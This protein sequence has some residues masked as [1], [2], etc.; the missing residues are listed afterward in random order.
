MGFATNAAYVHI[1]KNETAETRLHLGELEAFA[2]GVTPNGSGGATFGGMATSTNDIGDGTLSAFGVGNI[3]PA[4]GTTNSI[5]HGSANQNPDNLLQK[6]GAVWSTN[7][8]QATASQ[9][10]LSL[11]GTHDVT[12]IRMWPRADNCC[13]DRWRNLEIQLLDAGRN[14]IPGTK[15][16]AT[17][18]G[19]N[20]PLEFL[21]PDASSINRFGLSPQTIASDDPVTLSWN[22]DPAVTAV[23]IDQSIGNVMPQTAAGIGSILLDPGPTATTTYTLSVTS[24]G[25][26]STAEVTVTVDNDPIIHSFGSN[27]T[28]VS[29]GIDVTL[30]WDVSNFDELRL[31]GSLVEGGGTS[32][33][34]TPLV[35][36]TYTLD[37]SNAQGSA[38]A[39]LT[40]TV[41]NV[42]GL[43]GASGRF[44]EVVKNDTANTR[45]H[46]SEIEVFQFG[47][48]PNEA[49]GDG[50][51]SNDLIQN[52]SPSTETPPTTTSLDHGD[53]NFVFNGEIESG[54]SVWSTAGD[55]GVEPRYMLDL[56]GSN[57]INTVRIFGRGD[58]CCFDR[59]Q[60]FTVNIYA[61]DGTG[62]PG[63][64]VNSEHFSG[65]APAG[66]AGNIE[67]SLA[68]PDP[69]I[70][71]FS[72]DKSFIP[73]GEAITLAWEV[74]SESSGVSISNI[75]DVTA[76]TDAD[77]VGSILV[78][79]GPDSNTTYTLTAVRPNG[80]STAQISVEVTDQPLIFSFTAAAGIVSP[81]TIVN[82][83]WEVGNVSA[84][85]LN[86][87]D[88]TGLNGTSVMPLST[89]SYTLTAT[90]ANGSISDEVRIRVAL[91][92]EPFISEFMTDNE[93]GLTDEDGEFSDWI[94]VCNPTGD[95]ATLDGYFLT[96]D[97]LT[98]TKWRLPD[99][100]IPPGGYLVIFA[101]GKN[102]AVPGSELHANFSLGRNGEYLALV[103]PDGVTIVTEFSPTYPNQRSDVSF[104]FDSVDLIEGF[105]LNP[106]PGVEN[107]GGF[108]DF[109]ADTSFALDRGFYDAPISVV[110]SS[111]TPG[112]EIR[113][114]VNG[115]KPTP[116]TGLV[117]TAA[118][119]IARTTVLRAAAFKTGHVPTNIDTH[120]YIFPTD[121]IAHPN[122]RTSVT[123]NPTYAS[124]MVDAL[125]AVPTI[126]LVFQGD[127][128]RNEKVASVELINF[129]A[130]DTQL[131]AGMERF[132]N[133]ATN[134]A[135]RG[136]R[137]SF[138]DIYGPGKLTFPVFDGHDYPTP[139][140]AKIDAIDLRSGNHDMSSRGAY[141][142]NRF[143]DDTMLDMGQIAPHGRFVHIYLN[144][145]YWGQYH[146]RE[147]WN[148]AMMSEY[149][150]GGK[151]DYEAINA[152]N[153][154]NEFLTGTPFDGTGQYWN[155]TQSLINGGTPFSTA[156]NHID[157]AN[158]FN[159]ML[160]W[161]SGN[162][163][164]EFRS[165]GSVPLG[166]PFK[167]FM[168]DADGFLRSS[169]RNLNHNG[170][171]NVM[172]RLA[173]EANPDYKTLL[174]DEIHRHYFNDGAFT[175]ARNIAR[176]QARVDEIKVSFLGESA[177]WGEQTPASWQGFQDNL[178]NNYFP[179]LT[180]TMISRFTSGGYYPSVVAPSFNQ[181]GGS[182]APGFVLAM[183]APA[184]T[185]YYTLDGSDPRESADPV[186]VAPPITILAEAAAKTVYVPTGASD[187]FTDGGG[188]SWND[189]AFDD[190]GWTSGNGGV[191]YEQG[192]GYQ[193]FFDINVETDM[194]DKET[195]CLIR[196]PFTI[197]AGALTDKTG[198]EIRVRYDDAYVA[199]L[200]GTEIARRNFTGIP[201]GVSTGTNHADGAAV[202]LESVDISAH[203]ALL[204]EG[205][206]NLLAIHGINTST[207]SS[208][209]LISAELRVSEVPAGGGVGGII[210]PTAIEYT[211]TLPIASTT[212][213][214][215]RVFDG[216]SWS[217]LTE[218]TFTPGFS[219]LAVSEIMYNPFPSSAEEIAA[220]HGDSGN[221]EF[222]ELLNSGSSPLDLSGV[223][224][225]EGLAFDFT[226]SAVTSLAPGERVLIV[227]DLVAFEF[228]YGSGLPVAGQ[229]MGRLNNG[230]ENV[231]LIDALDQTIRNFAYGNV[232]PWPAAPDGQGP[233]LLLIDP[234]SNPDHSDPENWIAGSFGGMPGTGELG[235]Q[236]F[237]DWAIAN[238]VVEPSGDPDGDGIVNFLEFFSGTNPNDSSSASSPRIGIDSDG[239]ATLGVRQ[240]LSAG[241]VD[242]QFETSR[243]LHVW[244]TEVTAEV[245]EVTHNGD[246]TV[247]ATYRTLADVTSIERVFIRLRISEQ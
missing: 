70:R 130:G 90:N 160:L 200:N 110:I 8:G 151:E 187:G 12:T 191:G 7:P 25:E 126:S 19:G 199:Y 239:R 21:F 204:N 43:L 9:Y 36:T 11:G 212:T 124:Q 224:F 74:N 116:T 102:R 141:M 147:R 134:F 53:P 136:M 49:D 169:G 228:R 139:P 82:L 245:V 242:V 51:S 100:T 176:L 3:Y 114:T 223:R 221:F 149:F 167:F 138:R 63:E 81:G 186:V 206:E 10:T 243:D 217:A 157:M 22:V 190:N 184:G 218:A 115:S 40:I 165:A 66:N 219:A 62:S 93:S 24:G 185:I 39:D 14:P 166:V 181:H 230:G 58:A 38:S 210:S 71:S 56:G 132:G 235:Q 52:G 172:S 46:I 113:Y 23:T 60:N 119:P 244:V 142:S 109:V 209:F 27:H 152:N 37:A 189:L 91:P 180:N 17:A 214:Q 183:T 76:M 35:T 89:T 202:V 59:L 31:N 103:R 125:K 2:R 178:L 246:G 86:G 146:M 72:V 65:T 41:I 140:A 194:A 122:M 162:S 195:T 128:E 98:Q 129:E 179:G 182:V 55:L 144:G 188:N 88:V 171:L 48:N 104:G 164:S 208:D 231:H 16:L 153:A 216:S 20:I 68:I 107:T 137:I 192:S 226:G 5:Q 225:T 4:L 196:I 108:T 42:P 30:M 135:K 80:T 94:E 28:S 57:T 193:N 170:P 18:P 215:A 6:A 177:R 156:R 174:A 97:P 33:V 237:G 78:N 117:Y 163:E 234:D 120:T 34:V 197:A 205:G 232:E 101:S 75:G 64:L 15:V 92:G 150:G 127:V 96:D 133:Y 99:V 220:G 83:T 227:N 201:N 207:G 44:I 79:P 213:A 175:P 29:P 173:S 222:L 111:A 73:Q 47:V 236:S 1:L 158:V 32:I 123:Q 95:P 198:A 87:I 26:V 241:G 247:T 45:L 148:A 154:G 168:K 13:S 85:D 61:D 112:A 145:L 105:F 106:T 54:G 77:G 131:E 50:T 161:V 118:I 159:F 67:L 229:Y 121:V 84:L 155:E 240:A 238:G 203:F 211:G 69:G 233:S 143:T